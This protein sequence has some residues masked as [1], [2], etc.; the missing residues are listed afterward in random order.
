MSGWEI[1][2]VVAI[3][4]AIAN[5]IMFVRLGAPG[6]RTPLKTL[7]FSFINDAN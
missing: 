1:L 7:Q 3:I 6:N 2:L 4:Y 5:W